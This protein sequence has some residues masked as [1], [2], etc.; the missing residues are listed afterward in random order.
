M[1]QPN[2]LSAKSGSFAGRAG[3]LHYNKEHKYY[4]KSQI[5][6]HFLY[7]PGETEA[8]NLTEAHKDHLS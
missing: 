6:N 4:C 1:A 7:E 3:T 2:Q 5:C 8:S